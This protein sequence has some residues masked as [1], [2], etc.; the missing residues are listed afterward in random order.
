MSITS[1]IRIPSNSYRAIKPV[2]IYALLS[3]CLGAD[4]VRFI[5]LHIQVR[6]VIVTGISCVWDFETHNGSVGGYITGIIN[7]ILSV[8]R[9]VHNMLNVSFFFHQNVYF[10]FLNSLYGM[11][12]CLFIGLPFPLKRACTTALFQLK[13]KSDWL[14]EIETSSLQMAAPI[15]DQRRLS[16]FEKYA[17]WRL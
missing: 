3:T 2:C 12:Y 14:A 11:C 5:D 15:D 17:W 13:H 4:H 6:F 9:S 1:Q 7:L 10:F 16:T 8:A